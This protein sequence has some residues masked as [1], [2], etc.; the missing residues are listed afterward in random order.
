MK[1]PEPRKLPSGNWFIQLRLGGES[2]PITDEDR[3]VCIAKAMGIKSGLIKERS[4]PKD[5]TVGQAIDA[6]IK[7]RENILSPCTIRSYKH[8]RKF[9]FQ[10]IIDTKTSALTR[11]K[12]QNAINVDAAE[13][14]PKTLKNAVGL[15]KAAITDYITCD[16]SRLTM[17]AKEPREITIYDSDNLKKLFKA[18]E[19]DPIELAILLAACLGLRRSEI[20]GLKT[21]DF[22]KDNNTVTIHCARVPDAENNLVEKTTKTVKSTRTLPCPEFIMDKIP[23]S[24]GFLYPDFKQN[25]IA[26]RLERIC[27]RNELP[28]IT[29]H[30][31][32]HTNASI[33]LA[34]NIP[35]KYAMERG[36]W[37]SNQ[38]MKNIY[39]HT[40]NEHRIA[41]DAA[42]NS[43]FNTIV[44]SDNA[45]ENANENN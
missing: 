7:E 16:I 13:V 38:T 33:M 23:E 37:S 45:N 14:K 40:L 18:V 6:Y 41:A 15:I 2:I 44:N 22:N 35:D 30:G 11:A 3:D 34:L 26:A 9:R 1:V 8:I 10:G 39:Q 29:L 42:V 20:L 25:Y 5:I 32:R 17:P 12:I 4:K 36:G 28:H 27:K 43:Y 21:E 24:E 19:N 31:L